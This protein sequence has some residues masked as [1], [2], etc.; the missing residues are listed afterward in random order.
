MILFYLIFSFIS[1]LSSGNPV[2]IDIKSTG[3]F[4][5]DGKQINYLEHIQLYINIEYSKRGDLHINLTSPNGTNTMLLSEREQDWST[6]GFVN[7]P[8]MSVHTW[9]ENPSG[10]W[11][12]RLNDKV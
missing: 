5:E 4:G 8:L 12:F 10:I 6:N 11:K 3:C 7:W 9:G 1:Q 2:Q